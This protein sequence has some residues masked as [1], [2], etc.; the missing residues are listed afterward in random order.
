MLS[1]LHGF[2]ASALAFALAAH[3]YAHFAGLR[4]R[5]V[6][7]GHAA[8]S[9]TALLMA[10]TFLVGRGETVAQYTAYDEARRSLF[11]AWVC[12]WPLLSLAAAGA[13][14]VHVMATLFVALDARSRRWLPVTVLGAAVHAHALWVLL[15]FAPTA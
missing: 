14:C 8:T 2:L 12:C 15:H 3:A 11:Y 13:G 9:A 4:Q 1:L 6:L 7:G 10:A 5:L